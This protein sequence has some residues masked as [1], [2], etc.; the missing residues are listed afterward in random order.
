MPKPETHTQ[1]SL[2]SPAGGEMVSFIPTK[3]AQ[4]G[5]VVSLKDDEGRWTHGWRVGAIYT[6]M[7]SAD[8]GERSRD[9]TRTRKASDI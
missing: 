6:T 7:P 2:I 9:Y 3:V 1:C 5:N 8:V 4:V